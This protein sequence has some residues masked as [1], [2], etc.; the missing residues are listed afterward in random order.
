MESN[1]INIKRNRDNVDPL[2]LLRVQSPAGRVSTQTPGGLSLNDSCI[3]D[4]TEPRHGLMCYM[5]K[6]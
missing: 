2:S 3:N 5:S 1:G 6:K 4:P